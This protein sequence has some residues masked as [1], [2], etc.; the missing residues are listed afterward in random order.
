MLDNLNNRGIRLALS[1]V[2]ENKGKKND[3]LIK[4]IEDN[5]DKYKVHYLNIS[6]GNCNYHAKDKSNNNTVEVLITNY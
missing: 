3:I 6:Y 4:W 5:K 1:N 2:L